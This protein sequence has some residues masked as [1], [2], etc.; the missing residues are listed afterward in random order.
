MKTKIRLMPYRMASLLMGCLF[1]ATVPAAAQTTAILVPEVERPVV[2]IRAT[3]PF[4]TEP[5]GS[6]TTTAPLIL[7]EA[8]LTVH[9]TGSVDI[10]LTVYYSVG[11]SATNG[12]DYTAL[13][14]S[15]VI[16]AGERTAPVIIHPLGDNLAEGTEEVL[17]KIDP[18][19]CIAVYPPPPGCYLVGTP[20]AATA[21][22]RDRHQIPGNL[23]P[24]ATI[25]AP[26]EGAVFDR[27]MTIPIRAF[28][29]DAD[30]YAPMLEFFANGRKIGE[31]TVTFIQAPPNGEPIHFDFDWIG[32]EPGTHTL[33]VIA[34]D[35]RG[36]KNTSPPVNITVRDLLDLP[37]V[38]ILATDPDAAEPDPVP[39]GMLRPI[40]LD[41]G[42]FTVTRSGPT[43]APLHVFYTVAGTAQNG[44]DCER[45]GG[46]VTLPS[47]QSSAR[48]EV[49]PIDDLLPE[50]TETVI[51][52]LYPLPTLDPRLSSPDADTLYH[53]TGLIWPLAGAYRI[54][55]D[56]SATV[57]IRDNDIGSN[58]PPKVRIASPADGAIFRA[59]ATI[60]LVAEAMDPDGHVVK[61]EF[62]DGD[63]SLGTVTRANSTGLPAS[64][65]FVFRWKEVPAGSY[66][67]T[68]VATDNHNASSVSEAVHLK[69]VSVLPPP[70]LVPV[71]TVVARNVLASEDA[72]FGGSPA[73]EFIVRRV[74]GG[75]TDLVVHF[76]LTGTAVNGVNYE[77]IEPQV[78]IPA[79][80]NEATV[81]VRPIRDALAADPKTVILSLRLP[82]LPGSPTLVAP[83]YRIGRPSRAALVILNDGRLPPPCAKLADGSF[84]LCRPITNGHCFRIESST[85]LKQ[86]DPLVDS[87]ATDGAV[88]FMD[89]DSP[90]FQNRFYRVVPL[91]CTHPE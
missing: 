4:A 59:P 21:F 1:A 69:T 42:T 24:Q 29:R 75:N 87:T 90:W 80:L 78:T 36:A 88:R 38:N 30:G 2:T 57:F 52:T 51:V 40:I 34:T 22:I 85:D 3:D 5:G 58:R 35:D 56:R 48:I 77:F 71:V 43:T 26:T 13:P 33:T 19:V 60:D 10:D 46:L 31:Q 28:T 66:R 73:G 91:P 83:P 44:V 14:G 79:G 15:V 84:H 89:P 55:P 62:F 82:P 67:I 63:R 20:R 27:G 6:G 47:G 72:G 45:L 49:L 64:G 18:P 7:D 11:G 32:A 81:L 61:V 41:L 68:A 16:P 76:E 65:P 54:G 23:P 53:S 37:V 8:V 25:T 39:P 50:D 86:W 17:L 74:G 12:K 70:D 9:R